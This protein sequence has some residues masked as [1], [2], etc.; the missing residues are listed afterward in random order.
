M[1]RH[2]G[3]PPRPAV[4]TDQ[5]TGLARDLVTDWEQHLADGTRLSTADRLTL[6]GMLAG[7]LAD[8]RDGGTLPGQRH[9]VQQVVDLAA[10]RWRVVPDAEL[11][12]RRHLRDAWCR[13]LE[14]RGLRPTSWPSIS[15]SFLRFRDV[16]LA[17]T[18]G[19][20]DPYVESDEDRADVV[21][22]TIRCT[23]V[24]LPTPVLED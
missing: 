20:W 1:A 10:P 23:A 21:R 12:A 6:L 11:V 18:D 19:P 5:E 16:P 22:L 8:A 9:D 3:V 17:G 13:N 7:A 15:R 24:P 2:Y 14:D 4:V